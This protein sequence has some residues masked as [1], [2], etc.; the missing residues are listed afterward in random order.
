MARS[1]KASQPPYF[2]LYTR[3]M[4]NEQS[5][6]LTWHSDSDSD[7]NSEPYLLLWLSTN[8]SAE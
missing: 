3:T 1:I 4:D 2:V 7:F 6:H 8:I 5:A